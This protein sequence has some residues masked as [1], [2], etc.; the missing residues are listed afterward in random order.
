MWP[1]DDIVNSP[2]SLSLSPPSRTDNEFAVIGIGTVSKTFHEDSN[3]GCHTRCT[4]I[5]F[6]V[7]APGIWWHTGFPTPQPGWLIAT[8]RQ[9]SGLCILRTD[10]CLSIYPS[11]TWCVIISCPRVSSLHLRHSQRHAS[12]LLHHVRNVINGIVIYCR[13]GVCRR[14]GNSTIEQQVIVRLYDYDFPFSI[15]TIQSLSFHDKMPWL[16][17]A[18]ADYC[19]GMCE[20]VIAGCLSVLHS[21]DAIA[22]LSTSLTLSL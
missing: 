9:C 17:P 8:A 15:W 4:I 14:S 22:T 19:V 2:I 12:L 5:P 16:A 1:N 6:L 18:A 3:S 21:H 10:Y 7:W 13:P 20:Q 11:P